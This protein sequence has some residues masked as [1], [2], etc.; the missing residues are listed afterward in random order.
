MAKSKTCKCGCK[1]RIVS[2]MVQSMQNSGNGCCIDVCSNP[3]I[4]S[5]KVLSI[6]APVIYDEIGINLCATFDLCANIA[7]EYPAAVTATAH[8]IDI[9]FKCGDDDVEIESIAGRSN[10][11]L[12]TLAN[13]TIT[14]A[15]SLYD[16]NCRLLGTI[17]PKAQYL[18]PTTCDTYDE[19]TNPSSVELE[20]FAP[21]GVSYETEGPGDTPTPTINTL[22]F[23]STNNCIKQGLNLYAIGKALNLDVDDDTITVGLTLILQSLYFSGYRVENEGKINTPKGSLVTPDNTNC[24]RFVAGD[25]L[26]LAIKP[27]EL[28]P[29]K[30]EEHYKQDCTSTGCGASDDTVPITPTTS[31]EANTTTVPEM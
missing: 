10:C 5:P 29:P 9:A 31:V 6:M 18:P 13:L 25:L 14:F 17:Y 24:L 30:C 1:A 7:N 15:V 12:V 28:G 23:M 16:C 27:L 2:N 8:V 19:D 3:M 21:Y 22:A 4:G 11:Y 26:D 20:I